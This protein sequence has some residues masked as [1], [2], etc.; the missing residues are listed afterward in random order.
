[1]GTFTRLVTYSSRHRRQIQVISLMIRLN[2][3]ILIIAI[4]DVNHSSFTSMYILFFVPKI[5]IHGSS[6]LILL[7]HSKV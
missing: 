2:A 5:L 7:G 1:M 4:L 6:Q 3:S